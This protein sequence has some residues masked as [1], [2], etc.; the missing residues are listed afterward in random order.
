MITRETVDAIAEALAPGSSSHLVVF[1]NGWA[2]TKDD[3][4][5][6]VIERATG[7][8]RLFPASVNQ[9]RIFDAY[10]TVRDDGVVQAVAADVEVETFSSN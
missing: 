9:A 8:A 10:D 7:E 1:P 4:T 3:G 5:V 6:V 2:V